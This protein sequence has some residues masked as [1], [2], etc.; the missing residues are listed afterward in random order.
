MVSPDGFDAALPAVTTRRLRLARAAL[1]RLTQQQ[2]SGEIT[3]NEQRESRRRTNDS[4][5]VVRGCA[6]S[7]PSHKF[8]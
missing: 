3:R 2:S 7:P 6:E 5:F 8:F 4:A 1:A